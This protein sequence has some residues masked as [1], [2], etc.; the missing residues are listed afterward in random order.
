M[1]F[2]R[3]L[4]IRGKRPTGTCGPLACSLGTCGIIPVFKSCCARPVIEC[5]R[6]RWQNALPCRI[7]AFSTQAPARRASLDLRMPDAM[8][9]R[10]SMAS[11]LIS[12]EFPAMTSGNT[13][14]TALSR[15]QRLVFR[16]VSVFV[17]TVC[18]DNAYVSAGTAIRACR[19]NFYVSL[20]SCPVD[21]NIFEKFTGEL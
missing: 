8:F 18:V 4:L 16:N 6:G 20:F 13:N 15:P 10:H 14:K 9:R 21:R 7:F 5:N 3:Y 12:L 19:F 1:R 11:V 17:S 2:C